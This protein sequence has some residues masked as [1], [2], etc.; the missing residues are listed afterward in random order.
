MTTLDQVSTTSSLSTVHRPLLPPEVLRQAEPG[1]AILFHAT[2]PPAHIQGRWVGDDARLARL[3]A[4]QEPR[5]EVAVDDDLTAALDHD[6]TP[7]IEV[8]RHLGLSP[9]SASLEVSSLDPGP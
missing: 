4:G 8:L 3:A 6:P 5:P 2:L 1:H 9:A 7:T